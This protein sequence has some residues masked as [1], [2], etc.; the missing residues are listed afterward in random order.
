MS[1]NATLLYMQWNKQFD[2]VLLFEKS[3]FQAYYGKSVYRQQHWWCGLPHLKWV[4]LI[5]ST[6]S[7][8]LL[9]PLINNTVALLILCVCVC[10]AGLCV[11]YECVMSVCVSVFC[12]CVCTKFQIIKNG[13][14][15]FIISGVAN[16]VGCLFET[17]YILSVCKC[18]G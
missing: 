11:V 7:N 3:D 12:V 17:W 14:P 4:D 15:P 16:C 5:K 8:N 9:S 13:Q 2:N 18:S 1:V 10:S 6:A